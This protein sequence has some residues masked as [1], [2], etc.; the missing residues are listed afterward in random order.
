[1]RILEHDHYRIVIA[2][3]H[4]D[5]DDEGE[6]RSLALCRGLNGRGCL[7]RGQGQQLTQKRQRCRIDDATFGEQGPGFVDARLC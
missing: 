4:H 3:P 5:L 2:G 1:M 6:G 7:G